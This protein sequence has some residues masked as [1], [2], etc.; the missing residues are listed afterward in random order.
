M[1]AIGFGYVMLLFVACLDG[2][3]EAAD[4]RERHG[5]CSL[6]I[7]VHA[8][9]YYPNRSIHQTLGERKGQMSALLAAIAAD[10]GFMLLLPAYGYGLVSAPHQ[11]AGAEILV[12]IPIRNKR[13]LYCT[14]G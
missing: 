4:D 14:L 8:P 12:S 5:P 6:D 13:L 10:P 11:S 1:A 2:G 9:A 7:E 3:T